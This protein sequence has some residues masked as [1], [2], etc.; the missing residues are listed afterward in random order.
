[1]QVTRHLRITGLVQA[2]GYRDSI[3]DEARRHG[4]RGWVRNRSDG[5]VEAVLVGED[6]DVQ[7]IIAWARRGPPSSRVDNVA[8]SDIGTSAVGAL[9]EVRPTI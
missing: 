8:V 6:A 5:S 2:V 3:A 1:M 4:V 7:N 9:F